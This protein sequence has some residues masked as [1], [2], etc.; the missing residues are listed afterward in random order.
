MSKQVI[1]VCGPTAI[2]KT[3][4]GIDIA[5]KLNGEI[6]SADSRQVYKGMDIG[7]GKDV[8]AGSKFNNLTTV[9]DFDIGNYEVKD[10]PIWLLD[11]ATPDQQVTIAD[12]I[13]GAKKVLKHLDKKNKLPIIVG[14]T[15][16]YIHG[17]VEGI[18][19]LGVPPNEELRQELNDWP[20]EKIQNKLKQIAPDVFQNMNRS[21]KYNPYRLIRKIEIAQADQHEKNQGFQG[22]DREVLKI[23]L[24]ASKQK[25]YKKIDQR[26]EERLEKGLLS[27]IK[28]LLSQGYDWDDPGF[29][30]FAYKEFEQYFNDSTPLSD[31]VRRWK[32]DEHG[33][34][35]SQLIWFKRD[36]E[37]NWFDI[38]S[39]DWKSEME[40][41]INQCY[42]ENNE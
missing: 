6:I 35:R 11:M 38:T 21:D 13:K 20:V 31:I 1:V 41:L 37:I 15:G 32:F 3:S 10:I 26:V 34:A 36:D 29:N 9:D 23:G 16:F 42:S 33:Y 17:L 18:D 24:K 2:G 39:P 14:G 8:P 27:E 4:T 5:K 40:N 7:T 30:T 22:L 19:T 25:I 28:Q 12:W